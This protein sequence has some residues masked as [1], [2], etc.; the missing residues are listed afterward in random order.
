[1]EKVPI[2]VPDF[3]DPQEKSAHDAGVKI[4]VNCPSS[5][6][7]TEDGPTLASLVA[8]SPELRGD[9]KQVFQD[10]FASLGATHLY[11]Y[12]LNATHKLEA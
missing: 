6:E 10:H 4:T 7:L 3:T 5:E 1:M 2:H 11:Y 9:T 8:T 12:F